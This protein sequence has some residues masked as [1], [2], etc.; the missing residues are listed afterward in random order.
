MFNMLR[1]RW[2]AVVL[3]MALAVLTV[4]VTA[5][6]K[7]PIP[8]PL[9]DDGPQNVGYRVFKLTDASRDG[10]EMSEIIW[11]PAIAPTNPTEKQSNDARQMGWVDATS[12]MT[13]APYPLIVFSHGANQTA[14]DFA[15]LEMS[16][17]TH[18]FVVVGLDH[19]NDDSPLTFVN[20][21]MDV[22]FVLEQLAA[23]NRSDFGGLIDTDHVGVMGDSFGAYTTLA[24]TGARIDPAWVGVQPAKPSDSTFYDTDPHTQFSDWSWDALSAYRAK[25]S[26]LLQSGE[27]WPP[28]TDKRI[29]ATLMISPCYVP[30]FGEHGLA[31][32][33]VPSLIVGGTA[34]DVCGYEPDAAYT[35]AHLGSHDHFLLT[36]IDQGHV[37]GQGWSVTTQLY[38]AFFGYYLQGHQTDA[39]YLTANFVNSFAAERKL[40]MAWGPYSAK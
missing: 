40:G 34:D 38:T 32:A 8:L 2:L 1:T 35:F 9:A 5:Q 20:R 3:I 39:Q 30:W 11:Y 21:P 17:V 37:P 26:P 4:P 25:F 19:P 15:T 7:T 23:R 6:T 18:E 13:G 16:L 33:T 22:L 10:R 14:V 27:L 28:Y 31:A 36:L 12:D 24:V 29:L